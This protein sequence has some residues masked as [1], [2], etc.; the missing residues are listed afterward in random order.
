MCGLMPSSRSREYVSGKSLKFPYSKA[1]WCMHAGMR[2]LVW[3]VA[4][5][6]GRQQPDTMIGGV[7]G[8]PGA[9]QKM[10]VRLRS[11]DCGVP[12]DHLLQ[13][14]GLQGDVVQRGVVDLA[15]HRHTLACRTMVISRN[16]IS[17]GQGES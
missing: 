5:L 1:G 8:E 12:V 13:T 14:R 6:W 15:C 7:V 11:Y 17:G 9:A 16:M 4:H 2:Q 3:I 10:V